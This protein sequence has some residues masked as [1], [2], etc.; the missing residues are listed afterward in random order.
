MLIVTGQLPGVGWS[1]AADSLNIGCGLAGLRVWI[2][3]SVSEVQYA[4][5]WEGGKVMA[6]AVAVQPQMGTCRCRK[7]D[8]LQMVRCSS[9]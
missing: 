9:E 8:V 1:L 6:M 5:W 3:Y 2:M 7:D 4:L